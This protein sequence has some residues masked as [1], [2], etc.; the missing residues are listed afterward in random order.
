MASAQSLPESPTTDSRDRITPPSRAHHIIESTDDEGE[1]NIRVSKK[2]RRQGSKD[3]STPEHTEKGSNDRPQSRDPQEALD[4]LYQTY[5][6]SIYVF[7][8]P[9]VYRVEGKKRFHVFECAATRCKNVHGRE[10][11]RNID[12]TNATSTSNLKVHAVKCF[13]ANV[14]ES[15]GNANLDDARGI[16]KDKNNL[17]DSSITAAFEK[18]G[19]GKVTYSTLPPSSLQTR[20]NHVRWMSESMRP[21]SIVNDPG[22]KLNMKTGRPHQYIP[23][24]STVSR[25]VRQCFL[26]ARE[27]ISTYLQ[28]HNG[29]LNFAFDCWT[30]PNRR[31]YMAITVQFERLGVVKGFLLDF[32]EVGARH[33]G[34]RLATEFADVLT[35][36]KI[37][38]KV[39]AITCDNASNND[40][41]VEKLSELVESFQGHRLHFDSPRHEGIAERAGEGD[42]GM[43]MLLAEVEELAD[44][45]AR[46]TLNEEGDDV[47]SDSGP[48]KGWVDD[49]ETMEEERRTQLT[50]DVLPARRM[51]LKVSEKFPSS[52][53]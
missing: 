29:K 3:V 41:M 2:I 25:D 30:A 32:V 12:T 37:S 13:G 11:K 18:L 19:K 40:A 38:D 46:D 49:R 47:K 23:S 27:K 6:S 21:F 26:E 43:Q 14:V 51:L 16:M 45:I 5:K 8:K 48:I 44:D 34:A 31:A 33:T 17:R 22:Y 15:V 1:I 39:L 52:H 20:A 42:N 4:K 50:Y 24:A 36:Y 53:G 35:N 9:P 10:V 7:F 28:N